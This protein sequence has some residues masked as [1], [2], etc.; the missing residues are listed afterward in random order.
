KYIAFAN[1]QCPY[2]FD[3][4]AGRAQV[5]HYRKKSDNDI[6]SYF[7]GCSAWSPGQKHFHY[8]LN[9]DEIDVTMLEKLFKEKP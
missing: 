8:K 2:N 7:I 3:T 5:C 4:C 1:I 9:C 6:P